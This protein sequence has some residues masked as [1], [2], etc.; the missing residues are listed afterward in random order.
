MKKKID[1]NNFE[2]VE[3]FLQSMYDFRYNT[4]S[5]SIEYKEKQND[6]FEPCNESQVYRVLRKANYKFSQSDLKAIMSSKFVVEYNPFVEYFESLPKW[7]ENEE[8]EIDK[9][10]SYIESNNTSRFN[11]HFKKALV[12]SIACAIKLKTYNK[13]AFILV[14]SVQNIGKTYFCRWLCPPKL[15]NYYTENIGT[16]KDSL[17]ALCEN[18]IINLDELA[19]LHRTEINHLKSTF[20]KESDKSRRPFESRA[21]RRER[22]ANFWGST[23]NDEFLIDPT[24]SVRWLCFEILK[25]DQQ[26]SI[27]V[28]INR[29]WCEAYHLYKTGFKYQLTKEEIEEN[30]KIN[31]Q[32]HV[33]TTE[34]ELIQKHYNTAKK[35]DDSVLFYT[36]TDFMDNLNERYMGKFK[37]NPNSI[38]R[39]LTYLGFEKQ[40]QLRGKHQVKGYYITLA[41]I[42]T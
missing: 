29:M 38:G 10:L 12:R 41:D 11:L 28:D 6:E 40:Q 42:I 15:E 18:F 2:R 21:I 14:S 34:I 13:H 32:F 1:K 8:S 23:N 16:D 36:A 31:R 39:A 3:E 19:T 17:I 9:L 24:G 37:V 25:I 7:N 5:N 4:I 20:S 22:T 33:L 30:D 26:Y 27:N 35:N